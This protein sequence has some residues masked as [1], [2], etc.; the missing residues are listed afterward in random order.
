MMNKSYDGTASVLMRKDILQDL[1][2]YDESFIRHQDREFFARI[3]DQYKSNCC[4][5]CVV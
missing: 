1:Q 3:L 2:G 4:T 5:R